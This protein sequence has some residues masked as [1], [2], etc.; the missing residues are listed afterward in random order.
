MKHPYEYF[1]DRVAL[2]PGSWR[3][4]V[5]SG[6]FTTNYLVQQVASSRWK[7]QWGLCQDILKAPWPPISGYQAPPKKPL[8]AHSPLHHHH[9]ICST[10]NPAEGLPVTSLWSSTSTEQCPDR[11]TL[12]GPSLPTRLSTGV[13]V[14]GSSWRPSILHDS[15]YSPH[16][17]VLFSCSASVSFA[18]FSS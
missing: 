12:R 16:G 2:G 14:G 10:T 9:V 13:E 4:Q 6:H 15:V 1:V 3:F 8:S 18:S 5:G 7:P 17:G 11:K